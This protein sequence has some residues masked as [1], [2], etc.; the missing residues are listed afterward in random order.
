MVRIRLDHADALALSEWVADVAFDREPDAIDAI[1]DPR[2]A[3]VEHA[4]LDGLRYV[5]RVVLVYTAGALDAEVAVAR[6]HIRLVPWRPA[7]AQT[8]PDPEPEYS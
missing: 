8:L 5:G 7:P 2:Q 3:R 6:D 4:G 1:A